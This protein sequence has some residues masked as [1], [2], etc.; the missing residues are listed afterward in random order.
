MFKNIR[1]D[2]AAHGGNWGAQGF[3]ALVVY[4]FGRW[5]WTLRPALLRK[6]FSL[7]YRILYKLAE[8]VT[9]I[10]LPCA[11]KLGPNFIIDH[12]GGIII[13]GE[14]E[15]GRNC[16]VRSGVMIGV[17]RAGGSSRVV[18]GDDVDI[19]AGAKILGDIRIGSRVRI[20][21]NAVVRQDVPD[22]SIVLG[23][24]AIVKTRRRDAR[25]EPPRQLRRRRAS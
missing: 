21:A 19:G 13:H 12:Y 15:F 2:L 3:W 14:T 1:H 20:G 8:I 24:P 6:P 16:R 11:V 22:D 18:F 25:A 4:R 5:R 10:T 7:L 9:G 23:D 17:K